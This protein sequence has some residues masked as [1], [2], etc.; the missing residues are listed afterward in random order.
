MDGIW[1]PGKLLEIVALGSLRHL[2][3][4]VIGVTELKCEVKFDLLGCLEAAMAS[5]ATIMSF[6]GNI[7]MGILI[8]KAKELKFM[9][10]IDLRGLYVR[11]YSGL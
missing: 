10:K 4:Y 7:N 6:K 5:E 11:R 8:F 1:P 3:S 2:G 9:V